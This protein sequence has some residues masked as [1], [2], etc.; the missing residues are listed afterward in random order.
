MRMLSSLMGLATPQNRLNIFQE[1]QWFRSSS[2]L[3]LDICR[4]KWPFSAL[5]F[6]MMLG[7]QVLLQKLAR[8]SLLYLSLA[9]MMPARVSR[10]GS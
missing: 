10:S 5:T 9:A 7:T 6:G 8:L 2:R 4:K 1:S 3:Y